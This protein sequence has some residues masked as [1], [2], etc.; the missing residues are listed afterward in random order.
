MINQFLLISGETSISRVDAIKFSGALLN[1]FSVLYPDEI[2]KFSGRRT[3]LC[4]SDLFPVVEKEQFF[5][6]PAIPMV[7]SNAN[8][9]DKKERIEAWKRK[10]TIPDFMDLETIREIAARFK[11]SGYGAIYAQDLIDKVNIASVRA[12]SLTRANVPGVMIDAVT[13]KTTIYTKEMSRIASPS[14]Y[15]VFL[16]AEHDEFLTALSY[17]QDLGISA[18]RSTGLGKLKIRGARF[19]VRIGFSGEGLYMTLSPFIPDSGDLDK[20]DFQ[21]SAYRVDVFA[22]TNSN[23]SSTGIYRYFITGSVL[24]LKDE[25]NGRWVSGGERR[26]INFSAV[27]VKV[28]K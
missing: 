26:L 11:E 14:N 21:K 23:G 10:K 7:W 3:D 27:Y 17:L 9:H 4:V 15:W 13:L 22:G 12:A 25:I 28:S 24:Y 19:S 18:R 8:S 5:P 2:G 6:F 20:I 16:S 1:A